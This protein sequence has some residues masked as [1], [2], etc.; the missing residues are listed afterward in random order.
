MYFL[1]AMDATTAR[2]AAKS[3]ERSRPPRGMSGRIARVPL[4]VRPVVQV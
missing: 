3:D 4:S 2:T 1:S